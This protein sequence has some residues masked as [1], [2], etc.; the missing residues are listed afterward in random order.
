VIGL[1]FASKQ[2]S[3]SVRFKNTLKGFIEKV[4]KEGKRFEVVVC[5]LSKDKE[6]YD[7]DV[8]LSPWYCFPFGSDKVKELQ[9]KYEFPSAPTLTI[10]QADGR[11]ICEEGDA[12]VQHGEKALK[13]W[14][15]DATTE[16]VAADKPP[17]AT[18]DA[19]NV[20]ADKPAPATE[21]AQ[22]VTADKPAP[23]TEDAKPAT[24]GYA[25][26]EDAPKAAD[27]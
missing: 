5:S 16:E 20:T 6:S 8:Q 19:K 12:L 21:D 17:P 1:F 7:K 26:I 27:A 24:G 4:N 10:I 14:L 18:E 13:K 2:V 3:R 15:K 11:C 22:E 25:N 23:A 9:K